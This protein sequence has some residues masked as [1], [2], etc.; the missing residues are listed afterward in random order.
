MPSIRL[1][2]LSLLLGFTTASATPAREVQL[3][4]SPF[5]APVARD[6]LMQSLPVWLLDK[7]SAPAGTHVVI[8][9][10]FKLTVLVDFTIPSLEIDTPRSRTP[11]LIKPLAI[12]GE[13]LRAPA[14]VAPGIPV[15][16]AALRGPE[17]LFE[18]AARP[19]AGPRVFILVGSPLYP[20]PA[21]PSFDMTADAR[22]PADGHLVLGLHDSPF[23]LAEKAGRLRGDVVQWCYLDEGIWA[24]E[25]HRH[26]VTRFWSLFMAGQGGALTSFN[27]DLSNTLAHMLQ[28]GLVPVLKVQSDPDD[29]K[30]VMH[31]ARPRTSSAH[32]R[33][34]VILRLISF[35]PFVSLQP[36]PCH[37]PL[38]PLSQTQPS[39]HHPHVLL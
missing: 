20:S 38:H 25:L 5:L 29:A 33:P 35:L 26:Q 2:L 32:L 37:L 17:W 13:W 31:S 3:G 24:N 6:S 34:L 18:A 10:A 11:R 4:L 23:G 1:S 22:Y 7:N 14:P 39:T 15:G 27:A 30:P 16:S 21:E 8:W 12:V 36:S 28:S 19:A 9:D